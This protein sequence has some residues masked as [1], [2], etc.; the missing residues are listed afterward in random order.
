[1]SITIKDIAKIANVSHATVSR[2]LND[3]PLINQI[4]KQRIQKIAQDNNYIPNLNAKS[5]VLSRSYNIGLFFSTLD[6]GTSS[7][8][9]HEVVK[10]VS[11]VVGDKFKLVVRGI[12]KSTTSIINNKNFD[13][14]IVMSQSTDDDEFIMNV[15]EK[16]IPIVILNRLV[17]LSGIDCYLSDDRIG[18]LNA[19]QYLISKGHKNIGIIKGKKEFATTSERFEGYVHAL[20]SNSIQ[21][22]QC[23]IEE[24][25]FDAKTGYKA[26][27]RMLTRKEKPT[28]VF[29]S[30]DDMAVG[31]YKAIY[32]KGL[33]IPNDI[34]VMGFDDNGFT[35]YLT[36]GLTTVKRPIL[37]ISMQGAK[38][39]LDI[40][41]KNSVNDNR[42]IKYVNT[43]LIERNSVKNLY[44]T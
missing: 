37:D 38:D 36:P 28:A 2:A 19:I 8:F 10:G 16:S 40:I 39:L 21:V 25:S 32:E 42:K 18:S 13:G 26:M 20:K 43:E 35:E 3:S 14:I 27:K 23:F 31:A 30:N 29:C 17:Q 1:M 12:D 5:L 33:T 41:N 9:F 34:S 4:T 11:N 44:D 22:N 6:L 24:G 15:K 7:N